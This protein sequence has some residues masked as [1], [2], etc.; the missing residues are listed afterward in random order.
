MDPSIIQVKN[1]KEKEDLKPLR[2]QEL[3]KFSKIK[4]KE[5]KNEYQKN[6]IRIN[7]EFDEIVSS[8]LIIAIKNSSKI[9]WHLVDFNWRLKALNDNIRDNEMKYGYMSN[10]QKLLNKLDT[11][12]SLYKAKILSL[13]KT[14]DKYNQGLKL[15]FDSHFATLIINIL[16]KK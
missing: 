14:A 16:I 5:M 6:K 8:S 1:S 9:I 10:L 4:I 3:S 15:L 13:F 11:S 12:I 7:N 2:N